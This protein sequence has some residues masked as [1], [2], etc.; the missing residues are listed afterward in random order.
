MSENRID[1]L[2]P[3]IENGS[4]CIDKDLLFTVDNMDEEPW[5]LVLLAFIVLKMIYKL[6]GLFDQCRLLNV[7]D[8][9]LEEKYKTLS[10]DITSILPLTQLKESRLYNLGNV[11]ISILWE[12]LRCIFEGI[13]ILFDVPALVWYGW[14]D[15]LQK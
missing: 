10:N 9:K 12:F 2:G 13:V 6:T 7:N 1:F 4:T 8:E 11:S 14:L 3:I 5:K 15:V